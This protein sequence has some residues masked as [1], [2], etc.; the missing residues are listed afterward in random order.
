MEQRDSYL[1][2]AFL[3]LMA[4]TVVFECILAYWMN[5]A[6]N[7]FLKRFAWGVARGL[8]DWISKFH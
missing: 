1:E 5:F 2:P 4:T 8:Y 6:Q 3:A 7:K